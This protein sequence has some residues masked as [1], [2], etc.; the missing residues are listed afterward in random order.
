M[1]SQ[2]VNDEVYSSGRS[3]EPQH[4]WSGERYCL[5]T[6]AV[7]AG[8]KRRDRNTC[9]IT[10]TRCQCCDLRVI[11]LGYHP[12]ATMLRNQQHAPPTFTAALWV[13]HNSA[14]S[15]CIYECFSAYLHS[16]HRK[17]LDW[18]PV[19]LIK[20]APG[21]RL[22]KAFVNIPT[23]LKEIKIKQN[24][25]ITTV[26]LRTESNPKRKRKKKRMLILIPSLFIF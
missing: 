6:N 21:S 15:V 2:H 5:H 22:G 12:S 23:R 1:I 13:Q 3:T 26:T 8:R 19:K 10:A 25:K 16:H 7:I 17:D 9:S 24:D 14:L 18:D 20:T 4:A 11:T